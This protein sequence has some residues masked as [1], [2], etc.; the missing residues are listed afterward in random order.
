MRPFKP[1]V[2]KHASEKLAFEYVVI[3]VV[4]IYQ[5]IVNVDN[6]LPLTVRVTFRDVGYV[7]TPFV[8]SRVHCSKLRMVSVLGCQMPIVN[9]NQTVP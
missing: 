1:K 2:V 5:K 9:L 8:A 7:E 6:F 4:W 3:V